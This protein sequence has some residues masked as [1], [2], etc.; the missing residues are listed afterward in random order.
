M[1]R[2][3]ELP[4][5]GTAVG[6]GLNAPPGFGASVVALIARETEAPFIPARDRFALQS[7]QDTAV[8]LAGQLQTVAVAMTKIANDLRWMNSGPAAGL[9]EIELP[10]L[11]PGSSMMPGK[12]NPVIPEAVMMA[13]T[14]VIGNVGV[15]AAAGQSGNFQLNVMLPLVAYNLL[16]CVRLL[17]NAATALADKAVAGF[18]VKPDVLT[19]A[20]GRNPILA[21]ALVPLVGYEVTARIV[22][23][24]V[25][26]QR[27]I[28]EV[29]AELTELTDAQL[30]QALDPNR[31]ADG[32]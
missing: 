26:E 31:L 15:I 3:S 8:E 13:C 2:L 28:R 1:P 18:Q 25:A 21:T 20:L 24:A 14:Q 5:G 32:G 12:V 19:A 9:G 23:R 11:Q 16:L 22:Q 4:L 27:S 29:A 6:S 7:S 17:A 30:D 10:A